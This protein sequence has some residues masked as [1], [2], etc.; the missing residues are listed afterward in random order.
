M[1][2]AS[3]QTAFKPQIT[4]P[5]Q[6]AG[7]QTASISYSFTKVSALHLIRRFLLD[8]IS[9]EEAE[10]AL[11]WLEDEYPTCRKL[12]MQ[13]RCCMLL[14]EFVEY[15]QRLSVCARHFINLKIALK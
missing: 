5:F 15:E 3:V 4:T 13:L 9:L 7:I 14:E 2:A 1:A 12:L 10:K 6:R 8:E 11:E